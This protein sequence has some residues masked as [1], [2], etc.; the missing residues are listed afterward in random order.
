MKLFCGR[1]FVLV[2]QQ[3]NEKLYFFSVVYWIN[4]YSPQIMCCF[5]SLSQFMHLCG[6]AICGGANVGS[7][8]GKCKWKC[9]NWKISV[10]EHIIWNFRVLISQDNSKMCSL[11]FFWFLLK[12]WRFL[13]VLIKFLESNLKR[14]LVTVKC[15]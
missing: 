2:L 4:Y 3:K 10:S 6:Q 7:K 9:R 5:L 1:Y 15:Q 14:K 13:K 11:F 12:I 8:Q